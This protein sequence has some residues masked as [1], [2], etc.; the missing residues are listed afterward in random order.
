MQSTEARAWGQPTGTHLPVLSDH[1]VVAVTIANAQ[2]IGSHTVASTGEGE[3]LNGSI[4][5]L[6]GG[7]G[8]KPWPRHFA[9]SSTKSLCPSLYSGLV[10]CLHKWNMEE[11]MLGLFWSWVLKAPYGS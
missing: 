2:H 7:W 5:G 10:T 4:Q 11:V 1:D 8:W 9:A 3:L 6:P